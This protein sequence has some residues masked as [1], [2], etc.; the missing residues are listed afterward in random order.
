MK[1]RHLRFYIIRNLP[2]LHPISFLNYHHIFPH[3]CSAV[4][5]LSFKTKH[6]FLSS[7]SSLTMSTPLSF[8][9]LRVPSFPFLVCYSDLPSLLPFSFLTPSL[10][11][12]HSYL[13]SLLPLLSLTLTCHL[14]HLLIHTFHLSFTFY[15]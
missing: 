13:P 7:F 6:L 12:S 2:S 10:P 8:L 5:F 14:F 15:L 3:S 9:N 4:P 11:S 1:Y